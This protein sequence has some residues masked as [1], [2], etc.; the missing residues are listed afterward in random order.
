VAGTLK[1]GQILVTRGIL[2]P[3]QL[4]LALAEQQESGSKLGMT[5]VRM[6]FVDEEVLIRTLAGQLKLPVARIRGKRVSPDVLACIPVDVAEEQRCLP[7]FF[8]TEGGERILFVAMEDPS[9]SLSIDQ[10]A[11]ATGMKVRAVLVGPTE[12]EEALQRHYHWASLTGE[13]PAWLDGG[14]T[15]AGDAPQAEASPE[16]AARRAPA[17]VAEAPGPASDPDPDPD[18]ELEPERGAEPEPFGEDEPFAF[19]TGS[20]ADEDEALGDAGELDS[21]AALGGTLADPDWDGDFCADPDTTPERADAAPA[22][23]PELASP[24]PAA[25]AREAERGAA[26]DGLDPAIIL[27][28]LS[29]L[30]VEKGVITR[31]EFV[32]RLGQIAAREGARSRPS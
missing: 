22:R 27:R 29:Q 12:L 23:A 31:D 30:L 14:P 18:A 5:L 6:G 17:A 21:L 24:A 16:P 1:I 15:P 4:A 11:L 28:A 2:D 13:S 10:I 32:A 3:D 8:K 25:P 7:L 20:L 26:R 19:G 9:D